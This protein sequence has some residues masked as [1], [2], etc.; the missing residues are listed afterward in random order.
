MTNSNGF[1]RNAELYASSPAHSETGDLELALEALGDPDGQTLL[2]V[3]TGTGH[4]AF[5]FAERHAHVFGVDVNDEML[6]VAQEEAER[7]SLTCRFIKGRAEEL[8]FDDSSFDIVTTRLATHHFP[9]PGDFLREAHRVLHQGGHLL[10]VDNIVPAGQIGD[11]INDFERRRDP[12]HAACLSVAQ[13]G[14]MFQQH[15]FQEVALREYAKSLDFDMWMKRMSLGEPDADRLWQDLLQA[16]P[17][18][19]EFLAPREDN[20]RVFTLRRLVAVVRKGP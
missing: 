4:T 10:V 3:A 19:L 12:S 5:F 15:G 7:K 20:G 1:T 13:W 9:S 14:S 16:S 17:E 2:D 18:V 11:W 6:A 8:P